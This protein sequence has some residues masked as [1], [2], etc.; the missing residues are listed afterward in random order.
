MHE[1]IDVLI[2]ICAFGIIVSF[3]QAIEVFYYWIS[4]KFSKNKTKESEAK[5]LGSY[6]LFPAHPT[7]DFM[8][9]LVM[10]IALIITPI[11]K[12]KFVSAFFWCWT[13]AIFLIIWLIKSYLHSV[14]F[15]NSKSKEEE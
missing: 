2:I 6:C 3:G 7:L 9:M 11:I 4:F 8:T 1:P 10:I 12:L 15:N 5:D 14:N 13:A